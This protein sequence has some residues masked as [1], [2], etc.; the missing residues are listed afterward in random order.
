M[1]G[2]RSDCQSVPGF[3][4]QPADTPAPTESQRS[5]DDTGGIRCDSCWIRIKTCTH[6]GFLWIRLDTPV[7]KA[8]DLDYNYGQY[9]SGVYEPFG[10]PQRS[11]GHATLCVLIKA[12]LLLPIVCAAAAH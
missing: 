9:V 6:A 11:P 5:A 3:S 8:F 10:L 7:V 4:S 1:M 2:I 12:V